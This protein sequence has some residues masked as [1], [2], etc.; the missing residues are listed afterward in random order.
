MT[1]KK[2]ILI[3][4]T[5]RLGDVLMALPSI[6]YLRAALPEA[7]IDFLC[8]PEYAD[9]VRPYLSSHGV[10]VVTVTPAEKVSLKRK[11]YSALLLLY[12]DK[13][14]A[15]AGF[16]ARI[17][18][19]VGIYSKVW[20]F[21]IL[22]SGLR[23]KRS[24]AQKNEALYNLDLAKLLVSK[25]SGNTIDV[26]LTPIEL[27]GEERSHQKARFA[28]EDIGLDP[29]SPFILIHPGMGGSA[30]NLSPKGYL[31][32]IN[33]FS[34]VSS[35]PV[36]LSIGPS[37]KDREMGRVILEK[38]E[39][40]KVIRHVSLPVLR[41][42]FRLAHTVVAPSTGPIHLA[43]LVGTR[44]IGLYSPFQ[45]ERKERWAPFGGTGQSLV[46]SPEYENADENCME[47]VDWPGL[48]LK[49]DNGLT[50]P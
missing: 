21:L 33:A 48:I 1:E 25:V 17:A 46:L 16:S 35:F 5:D 15:K 20:S 27:K 4:R 18:V 19:R 6:D 47:R 36:V 41:E 2:R 22:T 39:K 44:T 30:A 29:D 49:S 40:M 38:N 7:Q 34:T 14:V 32:L 23:Q 24:K 31:D 3:A 13:R 10:S 37:P 26:K 42:I 43:H 11:N 45:S 9:V 50:H 8:R 28:L 12:G